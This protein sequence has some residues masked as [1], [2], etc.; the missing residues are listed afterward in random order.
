[1]M[2]RV[3]VD[4]RSFRKGGERGIRDN[5]LPGSRRMTLEANF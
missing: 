4:G 5:S 1:M 2:D 3:E